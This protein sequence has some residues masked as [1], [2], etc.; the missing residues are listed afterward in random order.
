MAERVVLAHGLPG[1]G[2]VEVLAPLR[3]DAGVGVEAA[4]AHRD[5][6]VG[7]GVAAE[8]RR[9]ADRAEQL[10]HAIRRRKST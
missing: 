2:E 10:R 7:E 5:L 4:E 9:A 8:Q 6:L 1:C 3:A